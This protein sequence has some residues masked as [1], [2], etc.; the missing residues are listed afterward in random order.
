MGITPSPRVGVSL[1][2]ERRPSLLSRIFDVFVTRAPFP[3]GYEPSEPEP[4]KPV[5]LAP[6]KLALGATEM[7]EED[8]NKRMELIRQHLWRR[9]YT[10]TSSISM[11]SRDPW[12]AL[13]FIERE[14]RRVKRGE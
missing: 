7:S 13:Q 10:T 14:T 9:G 11:S 3:E 1:H 8:F 4:E 12:G 6:P 5:V 2:V